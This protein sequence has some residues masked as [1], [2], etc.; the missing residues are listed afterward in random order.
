[1]FSTAANGAKSSRLQEF[2]QVNRWGSLVSAD[3]DSSRHFPATRDSSEAT[4]CTGSLPRAWRDMGTCPVSQGRVLAPARKPTAETEISRPG[5]TSRFEIFHSST[6]ELLF[7]QAVDL[8]FITKREIF[9]MNAV[10]S[11][12]TFQSFVEG[13]SV[14]LVSPPPAATELVG[15]LSRTPP[16]LQ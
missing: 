3:P 11:V 2:L 16:I 7:R 5:I 14:G 12:T 8:G 9:Q 6:S 4:G 13:I 10:T 15:N 1:M